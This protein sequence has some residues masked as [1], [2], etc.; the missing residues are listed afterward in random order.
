MH[1]PGV[2]ARGA[3]TGLGRK[4]DLEA[5]S[6]L[7]GGPIAVGSEAAVFGSGGK[8]LGIILLAE[9]GPKYKVVISAPAGPV[10]A[11]RAT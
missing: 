2:L 3:S 11:G 6:F 5:F 10:P 7:D 8:L 9:Q 4:I 1:D